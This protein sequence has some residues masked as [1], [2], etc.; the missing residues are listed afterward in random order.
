M[1]EVH[2]AIVYTARPI[3]ALCQ[4]NR[5]RCLTSKHSEPGTEDAGPLL[6]R[7][8]CRS[9]CGCGLA[10]S[11]PEHGRGQL[12]WHRRRL[13]RLKWQQR[14]ALY[15]ARCISSA[16]RRARALGLRSRCSPHAGRRGAAHA[17]TEGKWGPCYS[18]L[19]LRSC[20]MVHI[21]SASCAAHR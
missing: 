21:I 14:W 17:S 6:D 16:W 10:A 4:Q 11:L 2:D 3:E 15:A 20:N 18:F 9:P 19:H 13:W 12:H 5:R 7:A 1:G 8:L